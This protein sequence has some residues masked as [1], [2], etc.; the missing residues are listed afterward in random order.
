[1]TTVTPSLPSEVTPK[2]LSNVLIVGW[3]AKLKSGAT[4]SP[5]ST[6]AYV[7]DIVV[8]CVVSRSYTTALLE[9][10]CGLVAGQVVV[11]MGYTSGPV[12]LTLLLI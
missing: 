2:H 7:S 9:A 8:C 10:S 3:S 6:E 12:K 11:N 1:M 4:I 5:P